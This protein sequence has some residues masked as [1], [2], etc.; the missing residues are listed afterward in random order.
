MRVLPS[1]SDR[2]ALDATCND[3][4]IPVEITAPYHDFSISIDSDSNWDLFNCI[5][6]DSER[7]NFV[8]HCM[9]SMHTPYYSLFFCDRL[10]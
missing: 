10:G 3:C 4:L 9:P 1:S 5:F 7:C 2:P 6:N 8:R